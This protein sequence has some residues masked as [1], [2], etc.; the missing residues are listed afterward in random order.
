MGRLSYWPVIGDRWGVTEAETTRWYRCDDLVPSPVLQVWLGVT[1]RARR[2]YV[3]SWVSQIRLAPYSYDWIDNFGR[4]PP[5]ICVVCLSLLSANRS[6][7]PYEGAGPDR[8][9]R[10]G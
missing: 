8:R 3:W 6:L 10:A 1:V 5:Q 7:P 4:S 9:G 2:E